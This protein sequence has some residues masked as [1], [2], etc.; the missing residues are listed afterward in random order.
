MTYYTDNR[1]DTRYET[2]Y[3][4]QAPI[5]PNGR[6]AGFGIRAKA[7]TAYPGWHVV[8]MHAD[9]VESR[10]AS[11]RDVLSCIK[12]MQEAWLYEMAFKQLT[13]VYY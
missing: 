2:V 8:H 11:T 12:E 6:M 7:L 5:G 13:A 10:D 1:F 3:Q 4:Y 9:Y